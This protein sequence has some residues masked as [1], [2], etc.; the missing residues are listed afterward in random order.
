MTHIEQLKKNLEDI[1]YGRGI[2][3]ADIEDGCNL[4]HGYI[5]RMGNNQKG[6]IPLEVAIKFAKFTEFSID[7][8]INAD[9]SFMVKERDIANKKAEIERLTAEVKE[10]E[11][12]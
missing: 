11:G 9:F 2:T 5:A 8:L 7:Y 6:T 4:R 3:I 1:A 12:E 10:L